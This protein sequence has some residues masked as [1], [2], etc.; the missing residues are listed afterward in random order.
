MSEMEYLNA[1]K[2]VR[3]KYDALVKKYVDLNK[4]FGKGLALAK[5]YTKLDKYTDDIFPPQEGSVFSYSIHSK[6]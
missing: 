3:A 6:T 2:L 4:Q 1:N 5:N